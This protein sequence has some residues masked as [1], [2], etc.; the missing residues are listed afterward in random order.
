MKITSSLKPAPKPK[1]LTL[2]CDAA[3]YECLEL[4][5]WPD[6]VERYGEHEGLFLS[7]ML[8]DKPLRSRLKTA[9]DLLRGRTVQFGEVWLKREKALQ[10]GKFLVGFA[11]HVESAEARFERSGRK[12]PAE[13]Q[14]DI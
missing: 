3:C 5:Y 13:L 12:I 7:L 11:R 6:D 8:H 10:T 2:R 4:T 14:E 9:W 1:E